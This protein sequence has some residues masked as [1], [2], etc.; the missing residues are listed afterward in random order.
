MGR[1]GPAARVSDK[2]SLKPRFKL[3]SLGEKDRAYRALTTLEKNHPTLRMEVR[4]ILKGEYVL[5][6]KIEASVT[7]LQ[8]LAEEGNRVLLLDPGVR[9]H[10]VVLE[11]YPVDL[12]LEA[13]KEHHDVL[14][15][16]RFPVRRNSEPTRQVLVVH[17]RSPPPVLDLSC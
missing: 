5:A 2:H 7:L 17:Q 14:S 13:V 9:R 16:T 4:S 1:N 8:R 12:P 6:P 11:R 15:A 10:R 3:G